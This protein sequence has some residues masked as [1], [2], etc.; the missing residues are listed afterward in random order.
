VPTIADIALA[1]LHCEQLQLGMPLDDDQAT[2]ARR[3]IARINAYA[4]AVSPVAVR[5]SEGALR[6]AWSS[7]SLLG[8][9]AVMLFSDLSAG[10]LIRSCPNCGTF[11]LSGNRRVIYCSSSCRYAY[12]KRQWRAGQ[13]NRKP[14][15]D[16]TAEG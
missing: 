3:A 1:F 16:D 2:I 4:A 5:S 11:F 6:P 14:D 12:Q 15:E 7:P 13:R 9:F 10:Q 8:C